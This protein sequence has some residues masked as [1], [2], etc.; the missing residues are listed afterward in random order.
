[1]TE[2]STPQGKKPILKAMVTTACERN[3]YYCPFR[4]GRS[5]MRRVSF[6]PDELAGAYDKLHRARLVHGIFISP[7][8]IKGGTTTQDKIIDT[9]EI[10]RSKYRYDGFVHL[11]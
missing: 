10:L 9:V 2:V 3:C 7:G 6:Q 5:E 8:I 4:A 1:I 11:K